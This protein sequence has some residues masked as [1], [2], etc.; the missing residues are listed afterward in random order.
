MA[1]IGEVD[2]RRLYAREAS[3]SMF[4]YCTEVLHL[5]EAEAYLRITAA[6]AAREHPMLLDMLVDGRLHLSGIA[7]LVP[8]LSRENRDALL[9]RAAHRSKRQMLE[10][11]AEIAPRADTPAVLRKLPREEGPA[12]T[13]APAPSGPGGG[14]GPGALSGQ[15]SFSGSRRR[16]TRCRTSPR[17]GRGAAGRGGAP[18]P[19]SLQGS[20]HGLCRVL[21]QA[22]AAPGPDAFRPTGR[23]SG[24]G[25]RAGGH[26]EAGTAGGPALCPYE[27]SSEE[28]LGDGYHPF[29]TPHPGGRPASGSRA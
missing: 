15:S 26:G 12:R 19:R 16:T 13:R 25:H 28:P 7:R 2:G 10:L 27:G 18:G 14:G 8:H 3:P 17:G 6:R 11:V 9:K 21:R 5:S 24:R 29:L 4:A 1:H 22:G 20:V 23:R